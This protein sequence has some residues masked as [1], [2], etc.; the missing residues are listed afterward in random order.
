ML[1]QCKY[2]NTNEEIAQIQNLIYFDNETYF[3]ADQLCF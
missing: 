3:K 1:R 2:Y